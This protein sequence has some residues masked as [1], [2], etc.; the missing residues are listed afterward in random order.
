MN[1]IIFL[2]SPQ[3]D[4]NKRWFTITKN[5][6]LCM[7][8]ESGFGGLEVA[9]WPLLPKFAGSNLVEAFR[10]LREKKSSAHL[11]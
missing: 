4:G 1:I 2:F 5:I 3:Y 6:M 10:F 7:K 11:L 9:C 8:I